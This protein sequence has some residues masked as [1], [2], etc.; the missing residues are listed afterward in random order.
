MRIITTRVLAAI[1]A[2]PLLVGS[3]AFVQGAATLPATETLYIS[4]G[5]PQDT[6]GTCTSTRW[7]GKTSGDSSSNF[8]TAITPAD[9]VMFRATGAINWRDYASDSSLRAQGYRLDVARDLEVDVQLSSQGAMVNATVHARANLNLCDVDAAGAFVN[10]KTTQL[11]GANQTVLAN[12]AAAPTTASF[13][14]DL[15]DTMAGKTLRSMT[16]EIAVHGVNAAGGYINQQGGSPVRIPY[17]L[18]TTA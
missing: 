16:V 4:A 2:A 7:L 9:E 1:A 13:K 18:E 8:I 15:P 5:C 12:T 11:N 17:L 14:I 6:P 3:L 10:C